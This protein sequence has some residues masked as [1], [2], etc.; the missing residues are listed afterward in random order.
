MVSYTLIYRGVREDILLSFAKLRK[1][2]GNKIKWITFLV[3]KNTKSL[4]FCIL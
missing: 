4:I 1:D 2:Y 3:L